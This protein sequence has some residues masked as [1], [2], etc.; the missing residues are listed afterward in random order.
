M[1]SITSMV[2]AA[3]IIT[4]FNNSLSNENLTFNGTNTITRYLSV[5]NSINLFINA[6]LNLSGFSRI[7]LFNNYNCTQGIDTLCS[8]S[9]P[10]KTTSDDYAFYN[11]KKPNNALQS[12]TLWHV[13]HG[14]D[15]WTDS[16]SC[17]F[18]F[19]ESCIGNY[20]I[21]IPTDCWNYN[22]TEL[23]FRIYASSQPA[24]SGLTYGYPTCYNGTDYHQIGNYYSGFASAPGFSTGCYKMWDNNWSTYVALVDLGGGYLCY[25]DG[26][27]TNWEA[28]IY[29]QEM[30]WNI[31]NYTQYDL[32]NIS[33]KVGN[34]QIWNYTGIFNQTNDKTNDFATI[35][36]SYLNSTYLIGA[37]YIIPFIFNISLIEGGILQY[38]N[39][40]INNLGLI[41]NSITYNNQIS[42]GTYNTYLL[43]IT[44]DS[45]EYSA[46][47]NLTYDGVSYKSQL[48]SSGNTFLF[49]NTIYIPSGT[50]GV[51]SFYWTIYLTNSTG[52]IEMHN[53]TINNQTILTSTFDLC[54]STLNTDYLT[55]VYR[56]EV[57]GDYIN[58]TV[59]SS[60]WEYYINLPDTKTFIY[61]QTGTALNR[62]FCFY[63]PQF[64]MTIKTAEYQYGNS[65][66][67]YSTKVYPIR[68]LALTNSTTTLTLYL[69]SLTDSGTTPVTFQAI[70]SQTSQIL[71]GVRISVYRMI[72]GVSTLVND[73]YTDGSGTISY[74]LSPITAYT[75]ITS[76][77]GCTQ[78]TS[79]ITPTSSQ[80][81][82]L[83]SCT[84]TATTQFTSIIDGVTYT[85]TPADGVNTPGTAQYT[86]NVHSQYLNMTRVKFSL[87]DAIT[88]Q[89]LITNDSLTNTANCNKTDCGLAMTY[90]TYTGDN[91]KGMY[92]V[93]INGTADSDLI[94]IEGDAYWRFIK[95]NQNNSVNAIGRLMLNLQDFFGT[96][97]TA[98]VD[99]GQYTLQATCNVITEC[100]WV[101]ET[102]WAPKESQDYQTTNNYCI[103][104][105][106]LNKQEFNRIV[107]IF[108]LLAIV[109]FILGRTTGYEMN[110]PGSFVVAM[111]AF[112]WML[113]LYGMFT[114]NGLTQYPFF[115]QYIFALT[116]S[117]I[118]AGYGISVIRRYSG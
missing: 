67:G 1:L 34:S 3:S 33:L 2:S 56:D 85:R 35:L 51:K 97:G 14:Y 50:S 9:T 52:G 63:P 108:F 32:N 36:N 99:C 5:P 54:N 84:N 98:T 111:S 55:I 12:T 41:Q 88:R 47:A 76:G 6:S 103:P 24:G 17:A 113:S 94:L 25:D 96:W 60:S 31:D 87:I 110:H 42:D 69:I 30:I 81:N 44:Y 92:Y 58:A 109:L 10:A 26:G 29:E 71:P 102:V 74:Y 19:N 106:D 75:V 13:K 39:I 53:S 45:S 4:T 72:S 91:I 118:G 15:R 38:S 48:S 64:P 116:T 18:T 77:G 61:S 8:G 104:R 80:Y 22:S 78:L 117:C 114:F 27:A 16:A 28:R 105:D 112:I 59:Y 95:I 37:N 101:N 7:A 83:L 79:T 93:A 49:N 68:N 90:T 62:S 65:V 107:V 23:Y 115:N 86:F 100:K 46:A 82:I 20:N 57:T 43:N 11:Y 40:N 70:N 89:I 73:G 21:T 66:A